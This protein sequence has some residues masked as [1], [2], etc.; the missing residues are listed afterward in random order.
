MQHLLHHRGVDAIAIALAL[1]LAACATG[2]TY[3]DTASH[4][5]PPAPG[6]GR[7]VFYRPSRGTAFA[8]EPVIRI[9]LQPVGKTVAGGFFF[10]DRPAGE[11]VAAM[12]N[13]PLRRIRFTLRAGETSYLRVE[14]DVGDIV[15]RFNLV[16]AAPAQAQTELA[17]L[18]YAP[19][20]AD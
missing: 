3:R 2:P 1:T 14:P 20:A 6:E 17:D 16:P 5:A 19:A 11:H 15:Y 18:R 12:D 8:S 9:D 7:V 10:I 4:I 13:E